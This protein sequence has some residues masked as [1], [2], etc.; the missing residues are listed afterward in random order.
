MFR[1]WRVYLRRIDKRIMWQACKDT[2]PDLD[3][4]RKMFFV[5]T[6]M[7]YAWSDIDDERAR[8]IISGWT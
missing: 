1:L 4:A 7:D 2:A 3:T 5:H 6:R 8:A